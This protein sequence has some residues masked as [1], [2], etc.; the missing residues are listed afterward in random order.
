MKT[1]NAFLLFPFLFIFSLNC[2]PQIVK[3]RITDLNNT[4]VPFAVVYDET[5][6]TSTTSNTDGYYEIR[7]DPGKHSIIFKAMGYFQVKE[8]ITLGD[9]IIVRDIQLKEQPVAV[10]EVI[11]RP[12]KE[13]PA[14][15]IM[16]KVIARSPSHLNQVK[17]YVADVYLRG[18]AHILK[19]PKFISKRMEVDDGQTVF[20][21]G[22]VY[23]EESVNEVSFHAPDNYEQRVISI[24]STFPWNND[25][26]NPMGL[27]NS[28]L[29]QPKIEEFISPLAPNAFQY[30]K[31]HYDGFFEE[32][33]KVIFKIT[34]SPRHNSQQLMRG[35]IFIVDQLWCLHSADVSINMFFGSLNYKII[36]SPVKTDAWLPVSY[37]FYAGASIIGIKADFRYASSVKFKNV[38]LN[39]KVLGLQKVEEGQPSRDIIAKTKNQQELQELLAKEELT[40]RDMVKIA[41]RMNREAK[42]DTVKEKSLEIKDENEGHTNVVIEEGATAK[43]SAY[44]ETIRPIPL[45]AIESKIPQVTSGVKAGTGKDTLVISV[46]TGQDKKAFGKITRFLTEGEDFRM[47]D[48]SMYIKYEGLL[49]PKKFDFNTVDGFIFRQTFRVE[50]AIDSLHKLRF[51]PGVAWAFSREKLMW[52]T[53]A[54][55]DYAARRGGSLKFYIGSITAD[56]NSE[57]GINTSINSLATLLFRR[58]YMKLYNQKLIYIENRIDVANGLNILSQFGYRAA[59]PL[60]N[61]SDYSFFYRDER[62]FTPN[63]PG[64]L[65]GTEERNVYNEE[66]YW[67]IRL[68]FTPRYF[69]RIGWDGKKQYEHSAYPTLFVRNRMAIPGIIK[70]SADYSFLE[71]GL[72]QKISW[73]LMHEFSWSIQGGIFLGNKK[74]YAMDDKYFNNQNLPVLFSNATRSFRLLPFYRYAVSD[75]YGEA[76]IQYTT[77]YLL[78]KYLPFLSN[79]LWVENLHLNYLAAGSGIHYWEAG[80]SMGQIYMIADVGIFSGF[81]KDRFRSW[82]VQLSFDL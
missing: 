7:L 49:N 78:F 44:W 43:D 12:G 33:G 18:T 67:D 58:N 19:M 47:F 35:N 82:G 63:I 6:L 69:Y 74:I 55:Y 66:A 59:S 29:Y 53:S 13:D 4:A 30:Y 42:G 45:S 20:R 50:Q 2:F 28:S 31:Y 80:Y 68:E 79:K 77:P 81:V 21:S 36:Y 9:G 51:N 75:K 16:R 1:S 37:Q 11:I 62:N 48:S 54:S 17:E 73:A 24:K 46:G 34:V 27:I 8:E 22:D 5:T 15:A 71:T 76:H 60:E 40:N 23:M 25:E 41:T 64:N 3:G 39:E 14:Y 70:S 72:Y 32:A 38:I 61:Y 56:Y 10:K 57:S 65:P 26:I 52:W